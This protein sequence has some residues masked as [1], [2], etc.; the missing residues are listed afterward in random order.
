M[1]RIV[2]KLNTPLAFI[3]VLVLF[4]SINGLLFLRYKA[5]EESA[6]TT[7]PST[8]TQPESTQ[9]PSGPAASKQQGL[10]TTMKQS[11]PA[12]PKG[13]I[14]ASPEKTGL[15]RVGIRVV[16]A[17]SWL[18]IQVDG[19]TVFEDVAEPGF[20]QEFEASNEVGIEA[21][22][23]GAVEV[24]TNGQSQGRLGTSGEAGSSTVVRR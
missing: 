24:E 6:V 17:S 3:M 13:V 9:A 14:T 23:A 15:I 5:I 8:T 1:R 2:E 12:L 20:F 10:E 19:R 11:S 7:P 4:L 18:R 21:G 16:D 22:N